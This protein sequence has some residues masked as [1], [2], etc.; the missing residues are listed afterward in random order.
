MSKNIAWPICWAPFCWY[1]SR[2]PDERQVL[3]VVTKASH[4]NSFHQAR[5]PN[6]RISHWCSPIST[7]HLS[8]W[9]RVKTAFSVSLSIISANLIVHKQGSFITEI[10]S[11]AVAVSHMFTCTV[12]TVNCIYGHQP[13]T[14]LYLDAKFQILIY[15]LRHWVTLSFRNTK[16]LH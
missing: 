12:P 6:Q 11:T 4:S 8:P 13:P 7:C 10:L 15:F 3:T 9:L 5:L 1:T 14:I 2:R 16:V